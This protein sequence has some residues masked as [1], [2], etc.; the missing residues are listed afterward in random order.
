MK[1]KNIHKYLYI[2]FKSC[3]LYL[4]NTFF[5]EFFFQLSCGSYTFISYKLNDSGTCLTTH[6][7]FQ[8]EN[9]ACR[10]QSKI[11]LIVKLKKLLKE[12]EIQTKYE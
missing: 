7:S 9:D 4:K 2:Y 8:E 10:F 11:P 12:V 1:F 5:D 6:T 3:I